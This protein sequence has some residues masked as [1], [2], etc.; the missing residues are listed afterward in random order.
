MS[1]SYIL[2]MR[3]VHPVGNALFDSENVRD[4]VV[5]VVVD[6]YKFS[7]TVT[8][9]LENNVEEVYCTRTQEELQEYA[10]KESFLVGGETPSENN[11]PV[12]NSPKLF[13]DDLPVEKVAIT[14][15]NG[16]KRVHQ[17]IDNGATNIMLGCARNYKVVGRYLRDV[18]D[19]VVITADAH[20]IPRFE[21]YISSIMIRNVSDGYS[22]SRKE[23]DMHMDKII[24]GRKDSE[25]V[26]YPTD[27]IEFCLD[28]DSSEVI[29]VWNGD[30]FE[31]M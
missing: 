21:D 24:R 20:K 7:T 8:T 14:S 2:Y 29:P 22:M 6:T 13:R 23:E 28:S 1:S 26:D 18:D 12:G 10:E 9:A 11:N 15:D 31:R 3:L 16:A 27:E 17:L 19:V 30:S 4:D 25:T 5:Y